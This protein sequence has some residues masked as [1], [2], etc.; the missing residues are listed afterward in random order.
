VNRISVL[1]VVASSRGGGAVHVRDL[2]SALDSS[3][4]SVQVAM[5]QDGGNVSPEDFAALPFHELDIAAGFSLQA[6]RRV[7]ALAAEVDILH[8]HG[9]RAALFGRL[10]VM[11]L[12]IRRPRV[13]Y[14]IHGFAAPHY[15]FPK[16]QTLL[17]LES[18]LGRVTD[19]WVCVSEAEREALLAVGLYDPKRVQVVLNGI[20]WRQFA[21]WSARRA[22]TRQSTAIPTDA[23]VVT[24][25]CRLYRPR[26]FGTLLE[27]FRRT[28]EAL[29]DAHLLIVGEGPQRAE[30]EGL[31][32]SLSL[33]GSVHLLGLRRDVPQILGATDVFVLSSRG[34]EGLPLTVLEAMASGL[35]VVAS[36]VGGTREA[37]VHRETGYLYSPGDATALSA[38]VQGLAAEPLLARQMGQKGLGRVRELF[39]VERMAKETADLYQQV[40]QSAP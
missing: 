13:V 8:T 24:T 23:F 14:S 26:D 5:S 34:W 3:R 20:N 36:D 33:E 27:A 2:S 4:F 31:V 22:Q 11:G 37:V 15:R 7:G 28:R 16:R 32:I 10:A 18:W 40:L 30:V 19:L 21:G 17:F 39:S 38:C 29:P 1:E 25:V 35:P 6:I 12:G 9:A